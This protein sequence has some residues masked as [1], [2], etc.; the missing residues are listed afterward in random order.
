MSLRFFVEGKFWQAS[1]ICCEKRYVDQQHLWQR[2]TPAYES[3]T[4]IGTE[5]LAIHHCPCAAY[6]CDIDIQLYSREINN[7]SVKLLSLKKLPFTKVQQ[8]VAVTILFIKFP[9]NLQRKSV[10]IFTPFEPMQKWRARLVDFPEI[11][12]CSQEPGRP[13]ESM[14]TRHLIGGIIR[15]HAHVNPHNLS[16]CSRKLCTICCFPRDFLAQRETSIAN[17][18]FMSI[19]KS[20]TTTQ[21]TVPSE[22]MCM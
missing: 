14:C 1:N 2:S 21:L 5:V 13:F 16:K 20:T 8:V 17:D 18:K 10:V 11:D 7:K 4:T 3:S 15:G 12:K 9:L 6:L 22:G 19:N